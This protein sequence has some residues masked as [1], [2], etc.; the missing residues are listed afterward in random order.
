MAGMDIPGDSQGWMLLGLDIFLISMTTIIMILR[1]SAR[2]F[3][4]KALGVD[5]Y[6][7]VVAYV[8]FC[9]LLIDVRQIIA[10]S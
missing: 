3:M 4:T 10:N 9:V 1:I 8:S 5:D 6:I 2:G 7:A